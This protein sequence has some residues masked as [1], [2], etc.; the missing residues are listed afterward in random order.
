V[1]KASYIF[2]VFFTLLVVYSLF[3]KFRPL[4]KTVFYTNEERVEEFVYSKNNYPVVLVGSSLSGAFELQTIFNQPYF[5]LFM[6]V[7]G[8]AT[9][10]EIIRRTN[11]IPKELFIEIN[12]IDRGIDSN[13]MHEIFDE[14]LY[15][16]KYDLPFLLKKNQLI[17]NLVDRI[18]KPQNNI[19]NATQPP[20]I[21][22]SALLQ[23]AQQEWKQ[24]PDTAKFNKKLAHIKAVLADFSAKGCRIYFYEIPM[25]VSLNNL[26]LLTYQRNYF[27]KLAA[28]K[29][30]T[31]IKKDTSHTYMTGDG[32]HLLSN[33]AN[34][35]I[36]YFKDQIK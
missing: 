25:D 12:H 31:M 7:T 8:A 15:T 11:K 33:D 2:L 20:P 26:P 23:K 19:I 1:K 10:I 24:L 14:P 22:Y 4:K 32:D 3:L 21:L 16:I 5:N 6:P 34:I 17:P 35:F 13:L 27:T 9:G 36:K 30:Y 28:E 29:G 18:K